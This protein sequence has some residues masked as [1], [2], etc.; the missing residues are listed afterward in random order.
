METTKYTTRYISRITLE[1]LT[2]FAIGS[3]EKDLLTD[4][5][6]VKDTNGLPFLPGT[7]LA[8]VIRSVCANKELDL[9]PFGYQDN[10]DGKGS[11]V[12]FSDGV[13][14]GKNGKPVDGLRVIDKDD[15]FYS[16]FKTLPT[17]QHIRINEEGVS[18]NHGKFDE[19]V[20]YK[21]T[22]FCFEIEL[23]ST[24][25]DNEAK[26]YEAMLDTLYSDTFRVGSGTRSGFGLM[27]VVTMQRRDYD[28]TT[29]ADLESYVSRSASLDTPLEGAKEITSN[30][31]PDEKW[32][33]YTLKLKPADF[34][35]FSS[36][37]GDDEA[38]ITPV[39]EAYI[40][41]ADNI[42][43]FKEHSILI[44]ATSIKGALAHRTAYNWNKLTKRFTDV[45][46]EKPL[47]G[48]DNPAVVAIFGKSGQ[49]AEQ[50]IRRGNIMLSD[51]F[52]ALEKEKKVEKI[53]NHVAIDRFTGGSID[54]A[55]FTEKIINGRCL[56]IT[57]LINVLKES[58][59]DDNIRNAFE[60]SLQDIAEG[61][62]PLGGGVNRGYGVFTGNYYTKED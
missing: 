1:A 17:R 25:S 24:G 56:E 14:I 41:W 38:D 30:T 37:M 57:L 58:I 11:C 22:R 34:F 54:G 55:L 44:P 35:L 48:S 6:V 5:L 9:T 20:T 53:M 4:A 12:I 33:L 49:D 7:S 52:L 43:Q 8:G 40:E 36:G 3:G 39:S 19:Q 10:D 15:A 27:K 62:L 21:G 42:P 46:G 50:D 60:K 13:M 59:K 29:N 51:I 28:L 47:T 23:L 16:H 61:L 2:P 32:K 45:E 18:E 26:L 31:I